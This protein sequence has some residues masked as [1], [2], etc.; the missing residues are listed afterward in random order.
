MKEKNDA[1]DLIVNHSVSIYANWIA[2][3]NSLSTVDI[4]KV[5]FPSSFTN[6]VR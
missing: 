3:R 5:L 2:F 4:I 1:N 6:K